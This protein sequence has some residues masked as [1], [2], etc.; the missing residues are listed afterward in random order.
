[1]TGE[2]PVTEQYLPEVLLINQDNVKVTEKSI[3]NS[4]TIVVFFL[5][6]R[7]SSISCAWPMGGV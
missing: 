5:W 2:K 1:M 3:D 4:I 6:F 7:R